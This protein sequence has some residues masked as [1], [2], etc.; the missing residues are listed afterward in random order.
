M[1]FKVIIILI[2]TVLFTFSVSGKQVR[3]KEF[4][5]MTDDPVISS[6][7]VIMLYVPDPGKYGDSVTIQPS[8]F[9]ISH[10][11]YIESVTDVFLRIFPTGLIE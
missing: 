7:H 3:V 10:P 1:R 9:I 6:E 8:G 5:F 4:S 2:I 11:D